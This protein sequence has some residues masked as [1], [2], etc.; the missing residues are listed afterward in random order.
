MK[1]MRVCG[2][3]V[4]ASVLALSLLA[5]AANRQA[6]DKISTLPVA[7]QPSISAVLGRDIRDYH[8]QAADGGFSATNPHQN[9]AARFAPGGVEVRHGGSRWAMTLLGWGYGD[10]IA[11]LD[12][13][14]P[15]ASSNR[16]EYRHDSLTEWYVNGPIGIEQG[17]TL[18]QAPGKSN[19][20]PLTIALTL[21]GDLTPVVDSGKK[22]LLLS[23]RQKDAVLRY[24]GLRA[25]DADGKELSA[26][27]ELSGQ[28]LRLRVADNGARYPVVIDPITQEAT[29][30]SS[31]AQP[32]DMLGYSVALNPVGTVA[33]VGAPN[34]TGANSQ[35]PNTGVAYVFVQGSGGWQNATENAQLIASDG[36]T[37]DQFGSSVAIN[38]NTIVVGAP[39][40]CIPAQ[41][42]APPPT[43]NA[44]Q[45]AAYV[46]VQPSQGVWQSATENAKLIASD[47][48]TSDQLGYSVA[49]TVSG[50]IGTV[51]AGAPFAAVN[52]NYAQG[53]AYVYV[54]PSGGWTEGPLTQTSK[55]TTSTGT[56]WDN[57]GKSVAINTNAATSVATAVVGSP[58]NQLQ[59]N[60][61]KG[62]AFVFVEPSGGWTASMTPSATLL[63]SDGHTADE[64]GFVAISGDSTTI[65]VGAPWNL[66]NAKASLEGAA[67]VFVEPS[68]G[69]SGTLKQTGKLTAS[70]GKQPNY[71]GNVV[72]I[73]S[74]NSTIVVGAP[75]YTIKPPVPSLGAAY[76]FFQPSGGWASASEAASVTGKTT[77][78][79]F[80]SG[81]AVN[82]GT[83]VIGTPGSAVNGYNSGEADVFSVSP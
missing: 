68:G 3:G 82:S 14:T 6:S 29:L 25:Y 49:V 61:L 30:T 17:F 48:N 53:A 50:G 70:D 13:A 47:G 58:Y 42:C 75:N 74:D 24:T 18:N 26:S 40:A 41:S 19:G 78:F 65:V 33:V 59:P 62:A 7:A 23:N 38:N 71:F 2:L 44:W 43:G 56:V 31:N 55:F 11:K 77:G 80:G 66:G 1:R 72:A 10:A 67:Y 81:M 79:F 35:N 60:Q 12:A 54:E 64:F 63:A 27:L 34:A 21:S 36:A 4:L 8:V 83:M 16:V 20:R 52:N 32:G 9:L 69:W 15:Q 57:F 46:F 28:Q 76:V 37:G 5:S 22:S 73:S 45:G 39:L 51:I